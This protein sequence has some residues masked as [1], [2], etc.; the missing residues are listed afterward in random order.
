M[1]AEP[2]GARCDEVSKAA[3][4]P[5]CLQPPPKGLWS[6]A[7]HPPQ[8]AMNEQAAGGTSS[9]TPYQLSFLNHFSNWGWRQR[10]SPCEPQ[11]LSHLAGCSVAL[12]S[13]EPS[14]SHTVLDVCASRGAPTAVSPVTLLT[15]Q[16]FQPWL[17]QNHSPFNSS[18][19]FGAENRGNGSMAFIAF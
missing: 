8:Q 11:V 3:L 6:S 10:L 15:Q 9:H 2:A 7:G 17:L 18:L 5:F 4:L 14:T 16:S 12:Q 1:Q 19:H 13:L